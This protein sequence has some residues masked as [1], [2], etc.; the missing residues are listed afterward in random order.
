MPQYYGWDVGGAHLKFAVL[1]DA[2]ALQDVR[3]LVCPL[4]QGEERLVSLLR[5]VSAEFPLERGHHALTM[6]GELCDIFANRETGVRAILKVMVAAIGS[7]PAIYAGERGW[8][9]TAAATDTPLAVASQNWHATAAWIARRFDTAILIDIGSTT[10]D[11][12]AIRDGMVCAVGDSD[13]ARL[14]A[15]E[16][17]YS[18]VTRTPVMAV[19]NQVPFNGRWRG[20]AAEYFATLADVYRVTEELPADADGHP[21]ADGR[22]ADLLHSVARLARMFGEDAVDNDHHAIREGARFIAFTQLTQVQRGLAQVM[23]RNSATPLI[24]GA[25]TGEFLARR[26]A[27]ANQIRYRSFA[28]T[29][30]APIHLSRAASVCAPAVAVAKLAYLDRP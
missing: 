20:I 14:E 24:V 23:S 4:W 17:V 28:E 21:T 19:V 26:L 22:P 3:Q 25:G 18:G 29:I 8:F 30:D 6:T 27:D 7:A 15:G 11:I 9:E 12:I 13:G 10:T 1:D 2:G 16:L 5:S